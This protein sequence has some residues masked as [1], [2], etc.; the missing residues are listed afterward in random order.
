MLFL[1]TANSTVKFK[2]WLEATVALS[3]SQSGVVAASLLSDATLSNCSS[4]LWLTSGPPVWAD[5]KSLSFFFWRSI[6]H[7]S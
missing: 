4:A 3:L 5:K 6:M 2:T 1:I 7:L